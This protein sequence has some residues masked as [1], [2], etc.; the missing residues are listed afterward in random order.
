MKK[1]NNNF[2]S[3]VRFYSRLFP[4]IF[5][6]GKNSYLYN[7]KGEAYLDFFCG[8]GSLNYGHNN[9]QMKQAILAYLKE[10]GV[11][12]SL[13]QLTEAKYAFMDTFQKIILKPRNYNYK[14]QFCGP[15]GTN[16]VEAALKLARKYTRRE[17]IIYFNYSFHGMTYG[18]MSISG[19]K[20]RKLNQDYQKH[21]VG[22]PYA[23][24]YN[25]SLD[26]LKQYLNRCATS[27]LPAAIILE[28]IQAEGG[29]NVG[30][31]EWLEGIDQLAK[32]FG[33]LLIIDDI[34]AGCGRTGNFFSTEG[35]NIDPDIFCL[36]KSLS[37]LG[38]PFAMNLIKAEIDCWDPG[39]HNGTFRGNNLAF[40]AA[41]TASQFWEGN[42]FSNTIK[43][44]VTILEKFFSSDEVMK[45]I[46]LRGRGL[47]RGMKFKQEEQAVRLQ[48]QLFKNKILVD[49]CGKNSEV[50][51]IMPPINVSKADLEK[52]L[53]TIRTSILQTQEVLQ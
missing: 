45:K 32:Q 48:K 2:E 39:E 17:G 53:A 26:N 30:P 33:V 4:T 27:K 25:N 12:N 1:M 8:S 36:S 41:R 21:T 47:M 35:I 50:V 23:T 49:L 7:S 16:S 28:T 18:A 22:I 38:L 29:I 14:M 19:M 9:D 20:N 40:I 34:Q 52:G 13:D 6:K 15:T 11:L 31:K 24:P 5:S 44:K 42:T 43:S 10:D 46:N 3:E 37:G 51:K